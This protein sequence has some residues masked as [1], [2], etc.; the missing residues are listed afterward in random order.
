MRGFYS[1]K[2]GRL[3]SVFA[4]WQNGEDRTNTHDA[5]SKLAGEGVERAVVLGV[6]EASWNIIPAV[7]DDRLALR[8]GL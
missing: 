8:I 5:S 7:P 2:S 1:E 4:R 3:A 6:G